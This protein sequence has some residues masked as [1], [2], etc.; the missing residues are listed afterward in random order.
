MH[1]EEEEELGRANKAN[2]D[3]INE[4]MTK[5]STKLQDETKLHDE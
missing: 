4:A 1:K 5:T 2:T 3:R